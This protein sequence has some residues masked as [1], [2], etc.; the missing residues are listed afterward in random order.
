[1]WT[2]LGDYVFLSSSDL[3]LFLATIGVFGLL[4]ISSAEGFGLKS[5][6]KILGYLSS[7]ISR[8]GISYITRLTIIPMA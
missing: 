1:M 7:T 8:I 4:A 6:P 3:A 5:K 2:S